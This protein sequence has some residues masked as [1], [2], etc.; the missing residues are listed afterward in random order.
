MLRVL[1]TRFEPNIAK[2]FAHPSIDGISITDVLIESFAIFLGWLRTEYQ[3]H[4]D[5]F[6]LTKSSS[7]WVGHQ[8]CL[9]FLSA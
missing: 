5:E 2:L 7:K 9:F 1:L 3:R 4:I 6:G 8:A